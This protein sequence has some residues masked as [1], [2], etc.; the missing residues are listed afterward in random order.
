MDV[1]ERYLIMLSWREQLLDYP[2]VD[3]SE[4]CESLLKSNK[5]SQ[6]KSIKNKK[7]IVIT[8]GRSGSNLLHHDIMKYFC[9]PFEIFNPLILSDGP[10][11]IVSILKN[12]GL[13]VGFD[14]SDPNTIMSVSMTPWLCQGICK[15]DPNFSDF[16]FKDSFCLFLYRKDIVA[17]AIS[18]VIA[19]EAG[20]WHLYEKGTLDE[21]GLINKSIVE[22]IFKFID[23]ILYGESV[24]F[25]NIKPEVLNLSQEHSVISYENYSYDS[26]FISSL[27]AKRILGSNSIYKLSK[28]PIKNKS[29]K[30]RKNLKNSILSQLPYRLA[31]GFVLTEEF[32]FSRY[33]SD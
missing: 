27:I 8:T 26:G 28:R 20:V 29:T 9:P 21:S 31:S 16:I 1:E 15:V 17:Q 3:Y 33:F 10:N 5:K 19:K 7:F 18:Y 25:K 2:E 23:L 30:F 24:Y 32:I 12:Y 6:Y 11:D 4:K 14:T 13:S 22:S